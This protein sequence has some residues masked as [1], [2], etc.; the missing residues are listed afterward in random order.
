MSDG[1]GAL[2]GGGQ[3]TIHVIATTVDGTRV[4]LEAAVPL[5]KG[6]AAKLVVT[7]PRIVPYPVDFDASCEP[8]TFFVRRYKDLIEQLGGCATINVCLCRRV[9]DIAISVGSDGS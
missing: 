7:V 1:L 9:E 2:S 5:A 4:A 3:Q 6:A 8:T